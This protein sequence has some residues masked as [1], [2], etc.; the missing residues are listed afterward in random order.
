MV[1]NY[2][3]KLLVLVSASTRCVSI[4]AFALLIGIPN[5][6]VSASVGL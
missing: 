1:F 6:I 5:G 3:D 2:I 4:A